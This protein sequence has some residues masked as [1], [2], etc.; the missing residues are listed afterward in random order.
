M[1]HSALDLL[2]SFVFCFIFT[3]VSYVIKRVLPINLSFVNFNHFLN[4]STKAKK[5]LQHPNNFRQYNF[6]HYEQCLNVK[7]QIQF[8]FFC[9]IWIITQQRRISC[10]EVVERIM[11]LI[12][13]VANKIT[14]FYFKIISLFRWSWLYS[15]SLKVFM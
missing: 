15:D 13:F 2:I 8:A 5:N 6:C 4:R 9:F 10:L 7:F 3:F 14:L 11:V 12:I 1:E